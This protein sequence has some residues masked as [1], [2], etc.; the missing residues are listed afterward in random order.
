MKIIN[1]GG[2]FL[3]LSF[4]CFAYQYSF[5]NN[6]VTFENRLQDKLII[7]AF[8]NDDISA[9][10]DP[11]F[12]YKILSI[13]HKYDI[14]PL[15]SVI[16]VI[17][18]KEFKEGLPIVD[19][20]KS[21]FKKGW[22][23]LAMHGYNHEK[24]IFD[25]GEFDKLPIKEQNY[26]ITEGKRILENSLKTDINIFCPPWN[27]VD[28]NTLMALKQNNITYFSGYLGEEFIAGMIYINCNCNLFDSQI[29][30]FNDSYKI[31]AK[32]NNVVLLIPLFH[33]SYDFQNNS[34]QKLDSL[35]SEII[36]NQNV[37]I[38]SFS[39]LVKDQNYAGLLLASNEA[40]Y[41]LKL[42]R[43]EKFINRIF[44]KIPF[45]SEY[46]INKRNTLKKEYFMGNY[47]NVTVG[48]EEIRLIIYTFVGISILIFL[49]VI[50]IIRKKILKK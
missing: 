24:N 3:I 9:I 44:L 40:G 13:F 50:I 47:K 37:K 27:V 38:V 4:I 19:S 22:I 45:L 1:K 26:K 33:T 32:S 12:E 16:P 7:I 11:A 48:Y 5:S 43:P 21:W 14:K 18:M 34:I 8:R 49:G 15:Y 20:L 2:F 10:S 35:L 46:I 31:A 42:L 23:D 39:G 17:G 25:R 36:K 41:H 30:L 29:G 28:I 6:A